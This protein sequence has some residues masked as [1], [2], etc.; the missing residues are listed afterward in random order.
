MDKFQRLRPVGRLE[1]YSTSRHHLKFYN[2]VAVSATYTL[3]E[4][5]SLPVKDY[6]YKACEVL[7]GQHPILSAI[8]VDEDTKTPYFVRLPEIDL[9]QAISFQSR[10]NGHPESDEEDSELEALLQVQHNTPFSA[11][12]PFWRLCVLTEAEA[13]E[14]FT[15][16]FVFHHAISDGGSGKAFHKTFLQALH[17]TASSLTSG[18]IKRCI[19][20]PQTP[21]LPNIEDLHSMP[22]SI[23]YLLTA[24]FKAKVYSWRDPGLW[25][26]SEIR[27]PLKS[28]LRHIVLP[29]H[30]STSFKERCRENTT[31][32]TAALETVLAYSLFTHLPGTFT[33][34]HCQGAMSARRWLPD[35]ITDDVMGVWVQN[36][37]ESFS[38]EKFK[39]G[40]DSLFPW[41]EARRSR[42]TIE[43]ILGLKGKDTS[44]NLLKYVDD[45]HQELF[46]SK[47]GQ[48]RDA[49]YEV[50]NIGVLAVE[51]VGDSSKLQIGR[52]VFSQC[53]SVAGAGVE[54]SVAMG[55]DGCLVLAFCWQEGVVELELMGAVIEETKRVLY[56]LCV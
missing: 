50:S 11:P 49:S 30:I 35:S 6:V 22:L 36:W 16:A 32:I 15:V 28:F 52:V 7:I 26:G 38:R 17:D 45:Y 55:G 10:Q 33:K 19:P 43:T 24:L 42:Q 56:G 54:V 2:N 51:G 4:S 21:L 14:R 46:L 9:D 1:Q 23:P 13:A 5:C 48:Q 53:A 34:L 39:D 47:V 12:S 44:V 40:S 20:S 31:T 25:T 27:T 3:P 18:E 29:K 8:P 41:D 37:N